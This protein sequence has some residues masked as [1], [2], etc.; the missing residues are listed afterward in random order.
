[1]E[2]YQLT[3]IT[4]VNDHF[5]IIINLTQKVKKI[6]S[7]NNFSL[8]NA[9]WSDTVKRDCT[10]GFFNEVELQAVSCMPNLKISCCTKN[11]FPN[12]LRTKT[13]E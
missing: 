13:W 2:K 10:S 3:Y 9:I 5:I 4:K 8:S 11:E 1:M 12:G 7:R 6:H